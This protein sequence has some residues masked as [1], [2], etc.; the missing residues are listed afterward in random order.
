MEWTGNYGGEDC[1]YQVV[2]AP[3]PALDLNI[4]PWILNI[5]LVQILIFVQI[6]SIINHQMQS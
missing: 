1:S 6:C 2:F 4:I 3:G 5:I